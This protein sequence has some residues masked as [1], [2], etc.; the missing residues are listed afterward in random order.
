MLLS[1]V[2]I[3]D[4]DGTL[5]SEESF[6]LETRGPRTKIQVGSS[7]GQG[8]LDEMMVAAGGSPD[9]KGRMTIVVQQHVEQTYEGR[10]V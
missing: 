5:Q 2:L 8:T 7:R 6:E 4:P 9:R 1:Q 10:S 3:A